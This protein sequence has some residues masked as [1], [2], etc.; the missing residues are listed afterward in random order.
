MY[1]TK[2]LML[3][4]IS[5]I[6]FGTHLNAFEKIIMNE[7]YDLQTENLTNDLMELKNYFTQE[8]DKST[9]YCLS[10]HDGITATDTHMTPGF[11]EP[12]VAKGIGL[13]HPVDIDYEQVY[14][15]KM[16][17]YHHPGS[18]DPR[19]KLENSKITCMTCHDENSILKNHLVMEN[20]R[21]RLCLSCHNL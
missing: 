6:F 20:T 2:I 3:L 16:R 19:L 10:C 21:S 4:I 18:L 15:K 14:I 9:S 11:R 8:L 13:S 17:A 1:G 5:L 12:G 7:A